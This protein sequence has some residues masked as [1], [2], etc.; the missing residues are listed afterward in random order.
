MQNSEEYFFFSS[1]IKFHAYLPLEY[2]VT[3]E[4]L[5]AIR[6]ASGRER[7]I[8]ADQFLAIHTR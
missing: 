7:K 3:P 8:K 1:I 2:Q 6:E 5:K 4:F